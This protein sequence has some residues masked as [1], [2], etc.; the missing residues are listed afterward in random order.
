MRRREGAVEKGMVMQSSRRTSAHGLIQVYTPREPQRSAPS[1]LEGCSHGGARRAERAHA[2]PRDAHHPSATGATG[3]AARPRA[4]RAAPRGH[5]R[6]KKRRRRVGSGGGPRWRRERRSATRARAAPCARDLSREPARAAGARRARARDAQRQGPLV[7]D[8]AAPEHGGKRQ[9][10]LEAQAALS[11]TG[12]CG[13]VRPRPFAPA[14][15]RGG[16]AASP[17]ALRAAPRDHTYQAQRRRRIGSGGG[18]RWRRGRRSAARPR[19]APCA[20]ELSRVPAR[21]A[22]ARRARAREAQRPGASGT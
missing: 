14:S 17:R 11:R 6:L 3:S 22:S 19:A 7:H 2:G 9:A 16:R 20:R 21:A 1:R 15:A 13:P 10:S 5:T 4:R 8:E 18:T 12:P